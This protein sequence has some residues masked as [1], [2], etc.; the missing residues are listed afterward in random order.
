MYIG[1]LSIYYSPGDEYWHNAVYAL[2]VAS[3]E[4]A[5]AVL[6]AIAEEIADSKARVY[7]GFSVEVDASVS[8][9]P[10]RITEP[11][12]VLSIGDGDVSYSIK[13]GE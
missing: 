6:R 4:A 2:P 11:E 10:E 7:D 13:R 3:E 8:P 1:H 5:Y 9:M 12:A